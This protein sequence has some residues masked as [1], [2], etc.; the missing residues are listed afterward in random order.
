MYLTL[1]HIEG[2]S[3]SEM[4]VGPFEDYPTAHDAGEEFLRLISEE[5]NWLK[6]HAR[7]TIVPVPE[8]PVS[9][10]AGVSEFLNETI[11]DGDFIGGWA[12]MR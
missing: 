9:V 5:S 1:I 4:E 7:F 3:D 6:L 2:A 12:D 8:N 11:V 10:E